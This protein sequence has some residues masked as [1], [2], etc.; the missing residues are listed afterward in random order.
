M[1]DYVIDFI[2]GRIEPTEFLNNCYSNDKIFDWI[3]SI[4]PQ[5]LT[6]YKNI[7]HREYND[8]GELISIWAE[9]Q[10]VPFN[11][12][13][14]VKQFME[15][16][17][18]YVGKLYNIHSYISSFV[19]KVFPNEHIVPSKKLKERVNLILSS[20]PDSIGGDEIEKLG[21]FESLID[22][23]PNGLSKPKREKLLRSKIKELFHISNN[24]Y[25]HW[26]QAPEWPVNNGVPMRFLYQKKTPIGYKYYFEDIISGEIRTIEQFT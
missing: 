3:Q 20:C 17:E 10:V 24:K 23:L 2:E 7:I 4:V 25:P 18:S 8:N 19:L 6:C 15:S 21:I 9:Q 11:I 16:E 12:R 22:S 1:K 26:L 13:L 14:V 5:G